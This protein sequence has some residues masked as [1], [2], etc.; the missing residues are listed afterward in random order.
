MNTAEI[1]G[2]EKYASV[3]WYCS[4]TFFNQFFSVVSV[5]F[6]EVID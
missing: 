4:V 2:C 6:N 3:S 5:L 1:V